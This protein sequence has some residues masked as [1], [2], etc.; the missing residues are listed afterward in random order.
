VTT[1]VADERVRLDSMIETAITTGNPNSYSFTL[2]FRILRAPSTELTSVI[3][4]ETNI[5]KVNNAITTIGD[6]PNLTWTDVPPGP[7]TFTYSIEILRSSSS[8]E[9]NITGVTVGDR[10]L[11]AIVFPPA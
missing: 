6:F 1:T 11:D 3:L 2:T 5:Q 9:T 10:S 4:T 8:T 7:G